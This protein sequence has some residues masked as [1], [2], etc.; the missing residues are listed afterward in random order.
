MRSA[1]RIRWRCRAEVLASRSLT[2]VAPSLAFVCPVLRYRQG[3]PRDR[4][5]VK[6]GACFVLLG[7]DGGGRVSHSL[8]K[9]NSTRHRN[10]RRGTQDAPFPA[11]VDASLR[12]S[13]REPKP[14]GSKTAPNVAWC[15]VRGFDPA[16]K[17]R[18]TYNRLA[19]RDSNGGIGD[20]RSGLRRGSGDPR[21]A[22]ERPLPN[23]RKTR[24]ER[25]GETWPE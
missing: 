15:W 6:K 3:L 1:P 2:R 17:C 20:L 21:R 19:R 25:N 22:Q 12:N 13:A 9:P 14:G 10:R 23:A 4:G 8:K 7:I 24:A 16:L 11:L 5:N 18:W